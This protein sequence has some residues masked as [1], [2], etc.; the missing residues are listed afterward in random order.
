M[1]GALTEHRF[2]FNVIR[3]ESSTGAQEY[4]WWLGSQG[5]CEVHFK[6]LFFIQTK[7]LMWIYHMR[8]RRKSH[9][10]YN[11]L[12]CWGCN[13][14]CSGQR[15]GL[16]DR[17]IYFISAGCGSWLSN[18]NSESERRDRDKAFC[19]SG[20]TNLEVFTSCRPSRPSWCWCVC[21]SI[22]VVN[23]LIE[24]AK[25][26]CLF[27]KKKHWERFVLKGE[28]YWFK[29]PGCLGHKTFLWV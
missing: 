18:S 10:L 4:A 19:K 1:L 6:S 24:M 23:F 17:K 21:K 12:N 13:F 7:R 2:W 15:C 22:I 26:V 3:K 25:L 9:H 11:N 5:F 20:K 16:R 27:V 29:V 28:S 8:P 14:Y